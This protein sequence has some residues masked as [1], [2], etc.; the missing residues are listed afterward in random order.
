MHDQRTRDNIIMYT[1]SDSTKGGTYHTSGFICIDLI[2]GMN[3]YAQCT[4]MGACYSS[5]SRMHCRHHLFASSRL[6]DGISAIMKTA[7]RTVEEPIDVSVDSTSATRLFHFASTLSKV[8]VQEADTV[9]AANA[10]A[11]TPATPRPVSVEQQSS[12]PQDAVIS[13]ASV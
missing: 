7:N 8:D 2:A 10:A 11:A 6:W 3:A 5:T 12:C 4:T 9:S 13:S 1:Y